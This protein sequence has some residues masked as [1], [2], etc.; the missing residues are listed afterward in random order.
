MH[1]VLTPAQLARDLAIRDLTDPDQGPHAV[2][3]LVDVAVTALTAAWGGDVHLTR[4]PRVVTLADNYDRLGFPRAAVTRAARYTR[5]VDDGHVL[6]THSS[7]M[8]P[9]ALRAIAEQPNPPDDVLIV[10]PGIVYRRDAI[11]RLHTGTPHQLDLWRVARR[12]L[13]DDDLQEMIAVL[14]GALV[15]GR[16]YRQDDR[17]HPYTLHGRQVDAESDGGWVEV[18]ECGL[19]HPAVL[20][21]AGLD[22]RYSGLALGMGLDR[23]LMLRK[24]VPD[25]RLLRSDD[26]RVAAQ[27]LDLEPYRPISHLPAV[28]RDLSV[29]VD[30]GVTAEDIGDRVRQALGEDAGVVE[31]LAVLSETP[32]AALPAAAIDRLGLVP[33]QKNVLLR[34]VLRP[35]DRTLTDAEANVLRDRVYEE[36]H[37]GFAARQ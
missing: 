34:L 7:A 25:I 35:Y 11:D 2:Q 9:P 32:A 1:P 16:A 15:P 36:V 6:R 26:P 19:A 10:G 29:A 4:G 12:P 18:W 22:T 23:L 28:R 33:G 20:G 37:E 14:A 24:G 31:E 8:V 13:D 5:Y 21:G 17:A 30:G 27:M 3:L